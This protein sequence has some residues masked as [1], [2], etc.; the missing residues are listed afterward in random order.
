M[1]RLEAIFLEKFLFIPLVDESSPPLKAGQWAW[2]AVSFFVSLAL[3][4]LFML[5]AENHII[6]AM[7]SLFALTMATMPMQVY[8]MNRRGRI[9]GKVFLALLSGLVVYEKWTWINEHTFAL[10]IVAVVYLIVYWITWCIDRASKTILA[11]LEILQRRANSVE[12]KV[13]HLER[14]L[15]K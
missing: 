3:F 6:L 13:D 1:K 2:L 9:I 7:L 8:A 12:S 10:L 11:R 5:L 15:R 14:T 4:A